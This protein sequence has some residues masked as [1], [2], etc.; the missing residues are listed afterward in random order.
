MCRAVHPRLEPQAALGPDE[1]Y[2]DAQ[3]L[4]VFTEVHHIRRGHCCGCGCRHCPF[5]PVSRTGSTKVR[6]ELAGLV[7]GH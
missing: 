6:P 2:T 4:L 5:L 7:S 1:Y 3:G